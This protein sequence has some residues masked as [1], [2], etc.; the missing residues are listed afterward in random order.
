MAVQGGGEA[1]WLGVVDPFDRY[2]G[3]KGGGAGAAGEG[4]DVVAAG[5]K[6]GRSD[7]GAYV[8]RCLGCCQC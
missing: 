6:E 5:L 3:V 2:T 1:F 8:A 7:V 4:C